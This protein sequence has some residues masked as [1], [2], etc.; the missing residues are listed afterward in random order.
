MPQNPA[1]GKGANRY[2]QKVRSATDSVES[3]D[4]QD[5]DRGGY[6][7]ER[8]ID[9]EPQMGV[10][11]V[12]VIANYSR[13][14]ESL[15]D[16]G[17]F[18]KIATEI[19]RIA[20]LAESTVM[21]E[22]GDWFDKHTI[23]RNMSELKK[24][25][26]QFN[27]IAEDLDVMHQRASALYDDMG[28][29]LTRYFEL[30]GPKD[31]DLSNLGDKKQEPFSSSNQPKE[32]LEPDEEEPVEEATRMQ[33]LA[34]AGANL[35]AL[36]KSLARKHGA[37]KAGKKV[38]KLAYAGARSGMFKEATPGAE[39][40]AAARLDDLARKIGAPVRRAGEEYEDYVDRIRKAAAEKQKG[41]QSRSEL[42]RQAVQRGKPTPTFESKKE[43][44]READTGPSRMDILS[45]ARK[46]ISG[47]PNATRMDLFKHLQKTFGSTVD[48]GLLR[49]AT[50]RSTMKEAKSS[51]KSARSRKNQGY[52]H[53]EPKLR[54]TEPQE[55]EGAAKRLAL[56]MGFGRN[57]YYIMR[58]PTGVVAVEYAHESVIPEANPAPSTPQYSNVLKAVEHAAQYGDAVSSGDV[59]RTLGVK[60]ADAKTALDA[61]VRSGKLAWVGRDAYELAVIPEVNPAPSDYQAHKSVK[62][63]AALARGQTGLTHARA[64]DI[65]RKSGAKTVGEAMLALKAVRK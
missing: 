4:V 19:A 65:L 30:A 44:L 61:L 59:A 22:A 51:K 17:N 47:N 36:R 50:L 53:R 15:R 34:S 24:Y 31:E 55:T 46:F 6:A 23:S 28:N 32:E 3:N 62:T 48:D 9:A 49:L 41:V 43:G 12:S 2:S 7:G 42:R 37:A 1:A 63:P 27:K 33:K 5:F 14:G 45:A 20:E 10:N 54:Q 56:K 35:R 40:Q 26:G 52:I 21:Q 57:G 13:L 29:V 39:G 16:A 11:P 60:P 25:A 8:H 18:R 38:A 64:K 58:T